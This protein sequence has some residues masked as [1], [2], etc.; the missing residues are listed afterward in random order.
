MILVSIGLPSRFA[1]WCDDI[2]CALVQRAGGPLDLASGNTLAEIALAAI[3]SPTPGL[4]IGVRQPTDELRTALSQAR[5]R[6]V[7][8]LDDPHAAFRNLVIRHGLEWTAAV[9]AAAGGCAAILSYTAMPGALVLRAD[10][11]GNDPGGAATAIAHWLDLAVNPADIAMLV[12]GQPCPSVLSAQDRT[13]GWWDTIS[14]SDRAIV[15]GALNSYVEYFRGAGIGHMIWGRDLFFVGD[16]PDTQANSVI[17][18]SGPV[19]YLLFGPYMALPPGQWVAT[20]VLAVSKEAANLSYSVEVLAGA[21]FTFLAR[22]VIQPRGQGLCELSVDFAVS[23]STDQPIEF[24]IANLQNAFGG[25]LALAH[26]ALSPQ[27][28]ARAEI[29]AEITTALGL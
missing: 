11:E 17:D 10:Q 8:T 6:F 13:D 28:R 20:I 15:D 16:A 18:V 24:R 4:V 1:E 7:V 26:V 21:R 9:R 3:R 19:R 5:S 23:E 27:V 12:E 22:G 25:R 2:V 29:P 14:A